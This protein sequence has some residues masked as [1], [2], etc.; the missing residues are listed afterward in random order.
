M[1]IS[2]HDVSLKKMITTLN[3]VHHVVAR[4]GILLDHGEYSPDDIITMVIIF[5]G[6]PQLY[7]KVL[8]IDLSG[9]TDSGEEI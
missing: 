9:M 4:C 1:F 7:H 3:L 8:N 6:H 5:V 2:P